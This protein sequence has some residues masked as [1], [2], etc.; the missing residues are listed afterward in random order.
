MLIKVLQKTFNNETLRK[1]E[2]DR[3]HWNPVFWLYATI[4]PFILYVFQAVQISA[5]WTARA[6]NV[7]TKQQLLL[8]LFFYSLWVFIPWIAWKTSVRS[9]KH[10]ALNWQF[11]LLKLSCLGIFLSAIHLL[12]LS[13]ILKIMYFPPSNPN[14]GLIHAMHRFGEVWLGNIG[15]WWIAYSLIIASILFFIVAPKDDD[16]PKMARYE[17]R[18]NGKTWSVAHSDI[19]WIK[20]AGNYAELHTIRG[21]LMIRKTLSH[22]AKEMASS[23]FLRSHRSALVNGHHVVAIKPQ[24][25]TSGFLVQL[26]NGDEAPLSR[27]KLSEFRQLLKHIP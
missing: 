20:S 25:E 7:S 9:M 13:S 19:F 23:D 16:T 10:K 4:I 1:V 22:I 2:S 27:R 21:V 6:P 18:Q 17:I 24:K 5:Y 11:L 26:S 14:T 8:M 3:L 12:V 15:L